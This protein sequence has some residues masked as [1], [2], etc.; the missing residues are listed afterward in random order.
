MIRGGK[1]P[2]TY[3][4][5]YASAMGVK[6]RILYVITKSNWGGAQRYVFELATAMKDRGHD[7]AVVAGGAGELMERLREAE[8]ET[9]AVGDLKRDI[10]L[11]DEWRSFW[12][13]KEIIEDWKPDVL[14]LNSSKAGA[15]GA[16]A[17]RLCQVPRIVFTAHGWA[18]LEARNFF[19]KAA[20]FF[21]SYITALLCHRVIAVSRNDH[22]QAPMFFL[23]DR[24]IVIPTAVPSFTLYPRDDARNILFTDEERRAHEHDIWLVTNAELIKNKN[25]ELAIRAVAEFN[26]A[27]NEQIFYSIMGSGELHETLLIRIHEEDADSHIRLHGYVKDARMYLNAFDIFLLPSLKEGM[28]YA[29]LEAGIA[30]LPVI[31]SHVGGIPEVI[32]H[33]K[34]GM[35]IDPYNHIT[36]AK[37]LKSLI[38]NP[39]IRTTIADNLHVRVRTE[40]GLHAMVEKTQA[41]YLQ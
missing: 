34:T 4:L 10:N 21:V 37:V 23:E 41:L 35:L 12:R 40:Y 7:V 25:L 39:E 3:V 14:H 18:F 32:E 38:V 11:E 17:G 28:P 20:I 5:K 30:N 6:K 29:V 33:E 2:A 19:W 24:C 31:A 1:I 36:V 16:F 8:I 13:L 9:F 15:L 26:R 27:N 22:L